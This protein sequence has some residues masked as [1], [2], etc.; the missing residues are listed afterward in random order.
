MYRRCSSKLR[1]KRRTPKLT[2]L[3]VSRASLK[4]KKE[5]QMLVISLT[6]NSTTAHEARN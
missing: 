6:L 3:A 5:C 2:Q 4:R 1:A